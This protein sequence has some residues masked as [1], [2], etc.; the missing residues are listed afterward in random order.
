[1]TSF[2]S[3]E[4]WIVEPPDPPDGFH[5]LVGYL[6]NAGVDIAFCENDA[7][8]DDLPPAYDGI[9]IIVTCVED[10]PRLRTR[11]RGFIGLDPDGSDLEG[12]A[13][14]GTMYLHENTRTWLAAYTE[15][16]RFEIKRIENPLIVAPDLTVNSP[17]MR[18]RMLARPDR[19]VHRML[20]DGL[21]ASNRHEWS[22]VSFGTLWAMIGAFEAT[23]D[24]RYREGASRFADTQLAQWEVTGRTQGDPGQSALAFLRLSEITGDTRYRDEAIAAIPTMPDKPRYRPTLDAVDDLEQRVG[25]GLLLQ[26][27]SFVHP[28]TRAYLEARASDGGTYSEQV[29]LEFAG[30]LAAANAGGWGAEAAAVIARCLAAH[31]Q[32]CRDPKTGL[33]YHGMLGK[34]EHH[35]GFQGHG[36]LWSCFG[37]QNT[38]EQWLPEYPGYDEVLAMYRDACDAAAAVQNPET[39]AFHHILDMPQSPFGRIYTP[40]LAYVFLRGA[41]LGMLRPEFRKRGIR[42][43]EAIKCHVFQGGS[44]GGDAGTPQMKRFEAYLLQPVMYDYH[45]VRTRCFWQAHAANEALRA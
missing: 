21:L 4:C 26:A 13:P 31:R 5:D 15:K 9:R 30:V 2:P 20:L 1:M 45:A 22:D 43:W 41:R 34:R 27:H 44:V 17:A 7:L 33:Y 14:H 40:A 32:N 38:L 35:T 6:L 28:A 16:G 11:L 39:G 23:G 24:E 25:A 36:M 12:M 29:G 8:P 37:L 19:D 18:A 10:L 3:A 42:A